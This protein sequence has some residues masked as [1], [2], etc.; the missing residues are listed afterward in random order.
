MI[1]KEQA[2]KNPVVAINTAVWSGKHTYLILN[3]KDG[4]AGIA[5]QIAPPENTT[6][7]TMSLGVKRGRETVTVYFDEVENMGH[8]GFK[9]CYK[10]IFE[11]WKG[12]FS[13][14]RKKFDKFKE[15]VPAA[16]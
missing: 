2:S 15:S 8:A 10:M 6:K 11:K 16:N 1:S 3:F 12:N 4:T 13:S 14:G 5:K 7:T 9:E